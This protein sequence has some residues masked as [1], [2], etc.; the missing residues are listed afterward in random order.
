MYG[1]AK[2]RG[3]GYQQ[4]GRQVGPPVDERH[5]ECGSFLF[6]GLLVGSCHNDVNLL[7][8][9]NDLIDHSYA[10][11]S[12]PTI[13]CLADDYLG[14]VVLGRVFRHGR[15]HGITTNGHSFGS[16]ALRQSQVIQH[17][18]PFFGRQSNVVGRLDVDSKP[19]GIQLRSQHPGSAHQSGTLGVGADA[20]QNAFRRRPRAAY[21]VGLHVG[22]QSVID[23]D[24]SRAH[25][26][27]SQRNEIAFAEEAGGSPRRLIGNIDL[28]FLQPLQQLIGRQIDE[29]DLCCL[30][31]Y[32][33]RDRFMH[34]DTRYL[35]HYVAQTLNMLDIERGVH[36]NASFYELLDI[37]IALGVA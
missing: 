11:Q 29:F 16:H 25:S 17:P 6:D 18:V 20:H 5:S 15:G 9:A 21:G 22:P 19:F 26:Q 34:P 24:R 31:N 3:D 28:A 35:H 7:A 4:Q 14:D 30:V 10:E 2:Q 36:I 27:L 1:M 32:A 37:L 23:T 8:S 33:V 12:P 13:L